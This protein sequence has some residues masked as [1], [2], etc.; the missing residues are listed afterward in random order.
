[1]PRI[2]CI[3]ALAA[4]I[5]CASRTAHTPIVHAQLPNNHD[6]IDLQAGWRLT[7]V[8]PITKSGKYVVQSREEPATGTLSVGDDFLG[9][10]VAHYAVDDQGEG[11]ILVRFSSAEITKDG[12]VEPQPR[13]S[14]QL[15]QRIGQAKHVRLLYFLRASS[16]D[17]DM[18]VLVANQLDALDVLTQQVQANPGTY[19]K[20]SRRASCT[21]IPAGIAVRPE[22][23]RTEGGGAIW[24]DAR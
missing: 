15:F 23:L 13:P 14:I 21:W 8:T 12:K 6:F 16:A 11:R 18:A 19:C 4:L 1:M 10:E 20:E 17:H 24:V 5:G 22:S 3:F 7:V 9:Y 2:F